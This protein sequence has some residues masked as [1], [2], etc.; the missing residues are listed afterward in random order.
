MTSCRPG[1]TVAPGHWGILVARRGVPLHRKEAITRMSLHSYRVFHT[2]AQQ[3]SFSKAAR[4]LDLSP[5][6]VSHAVSGLEEEFGM[7][8]FIRNKKAVALTEEGKMVYDHV[9]NILSSQDIL[10]SLLT[11]IANATVGRVRLGIPNTVAVN[12]LADIVALYRERCPSIELI[13]REYGYQTLIGGLMSHE[14]DLVLVSHSSI[15]SLTE[16]LQFV[17]LVQ[18]RLVCVSPKGHRPEGGAF[19]SVEELAHM[20]LIRLEDGNMADVSA[21]MERH[22]ISMDPSSTA[23]SDTSIVALVRC[24]FGHAII[25]ELALTGIEGL[26]DVEVWPIVPSGTRTLGVLSRRS[27]LTT[28]AVKGMIE[29]ISQVLSSH[30]P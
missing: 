17:P 19:V 24:G 16:P 12:W 8:L 7:T 1:A 3:R 18:D 5:S 25:P 2:V 11:R 26:K 27:K 30:G 29:C 21:Y 4:L 23:I 14:F 13:V 22:G 28:P 6:A 20:E 15:R 9:A 10:D